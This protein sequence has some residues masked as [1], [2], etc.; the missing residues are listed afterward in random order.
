METRSRRLDDRGMTLVELLIAVVILAIIT[1]P[2][3]HAFVS[4]SRVNMD[5]RRN[6]RITTVAQD[7]MEGLRADTLAEL[8]E[9]FNYPDAGGMKSFHIID[10][11]LVSGGI[12]ENRCAID[13][14]GGVTGLTWVDP[15]DPNVNNQPS[16]RPVSGSVSCDFVPRDGSIAGRDDGRYYFTMEN[17][18]I[19]DPATAAYSVDVIIEANAVP[20]RSDADGGTVVGAEA[21]HNTDSYVSIDSMNEHCDYMFNVDLQEIIDS[22]C[23]GLGLTT[24]DVFCR[25]KL[26]LDT[27]HTAR[28]DV[29]VYR[30]G[31]GGSLF[32]ESMQ[33]TK[34]ET[35]SIF[36]LY[37]PTYTKAG[38]ASTATPDTVNSVP[39]SDSFDFINNS[40]D[41]VNLCL[42]KKNNTK[43]IYVKDH[44]ELCEDYYRCYVKVEDTGG[45]MSEVRTN[46]D[47][48]L[49]V[50]DQQELLVK[51]DAAN[52]QATYEYS[53]LISSSE[54]E[55]KHVKP[56]G[57]GEV[58]D[59]IYD[60]TVYVYEEG[61]I[62]GARSNAGHSIPSDNML[63]RLNGSI[64]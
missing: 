46:L 49:A 10:R 54:Y 5:A 39:C 28:L 56:L 36:V 27:G 55:N 42:V 57:G 31:S 7:V 37:D 47:Y 29:S 52:K 2:L 63:V 33:I 3:L 50:I 14:D 51:V 43:D 8:A 41:N 6:L 40:T 12:S 13:A 38:A 21:R 22:N 62:A 30:A 26:N 64:R 53:G 35:R 20:Y 34:P 44:L 19:E 4:A 16:V 60:V 59:R 9:E 1:V 24:K 61:S 48:N 32:V 11:R 58:T 15:S 17:V 25:Y 23:T 18:T 45:S